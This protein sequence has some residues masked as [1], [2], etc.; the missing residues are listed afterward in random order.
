MG[1]FLNKKLCVFFMCLRFKK[2]SVVKRLDRTVY[3][4]RRSEYTKWRVFAIS[5]VQEMPTEIRLDN[6]VRMC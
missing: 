1:R 5:E 6:S 2:K 4:W 3:M